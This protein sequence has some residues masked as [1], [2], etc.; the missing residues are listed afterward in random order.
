MAQKP[1]TPIAR[2]AIRVAF[3][4]MPSAS[5]RDISVLCGNISYE[6]IRMFCAGMSRDGLRGASFDVIAEAWRRESGDS[7]PAALA[8]ALV[9]VVGYLSLRLS[10]RLH[11]DNGAPVFPIPYIDR[12][13]LDRLN[14]M[15]V[16]NGLAVVR[17]MAARD[18]LPLLAT[19]NL[20]AD[21]FGFQPS[22]RDQR[23]A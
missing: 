12:G 17:R 16:E 14:A 4:N 18:L 2:L 10:P 11:D 3:A 8:T 1:I 19:V 22:E 9:D 20:V 15:T 23:A 7:Q 6:S 13:T 21:T 5:L